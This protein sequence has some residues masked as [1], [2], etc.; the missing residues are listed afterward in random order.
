M[1]ANSYFSST[2]RG[3][4]RHPLGVTGRR[5]VGV[6][7]CGVGGVA[8]PHVAPLQDSVQHHN[9]PPSRRRGA[10]SATIAGSLLTGGA[11]AVTAP[12]RAS[13]SLPALP[14]SSLRPATRIPLPASLCP[15]SSSRRNQVL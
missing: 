4:P 8:D 12:P 14:H 10:G 2:S 9:T 3:A 13:A 11:T 15:S 5:V 7:A 1:T 6:G